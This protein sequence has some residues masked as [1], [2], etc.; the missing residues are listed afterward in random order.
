MEK[1]LS[2]SLNGKEVTL[3]VDDERSLLWVLRT[4][5]ALTGT[6][7]GC[8]EGWCR[9][10]NVLVDGKVRASCQTPVKAVAG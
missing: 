5:L 6:K 10:C 2:F 7:F 8:G 4:D 3:A 1:S 9:V